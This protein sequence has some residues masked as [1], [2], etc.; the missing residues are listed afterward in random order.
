MTGALSIKDRL[1]AALPAGSLRARLASGA[2]WSLAGSVGVQ[3]AFAVTSVIV[4]RI[5]GKV[6]FGQFGMI[7]NTVL[8]FSALAGMGLGLTASKYIAEFR[9]SDPPRAGRVLGLATAWAAA[10]GLLIAVGV[11]VGADFLAE[12]TLKEPALAGYIRIC[13]PMLALAAVTGVQTGALS[14]LE[15]FRSMSAWGA[16]AAVIASVLT[17]A[18][19]YLWQLPGAL[20][21][22]VLGALVGCAFYQGLLLVLFARSGLR[23]DYRRMWQERGVLT[24]FALPS[25]LS[26][27]MMVPVTWAAAAMLARR[28][29]GWGELGVFNAANQ[30]RML[31][32]M[33]PTAAAQVVLP[34]LSSLSAGG[35]R[36]RYLRVLRV[37]AAV[38]F[39]AALA[40]ALPLAVASPWIMSLYG[41]GFRAGWPCLVFLAASAAVYAVL[42]VVGQ[43]IASL[44]RMWWGFALNLLWAVE[45]LTATWLLLPLGATGL[46]I[47]YL[48]AYG[49]HAV[50]VSLYTA[51]V[52]RRQVPQGA[53]PQTA[54][55]PAAAP[56]V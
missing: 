29:G 42:N 23:V 27:V 2:F 3:A 16:A 34:L 52:L 46:A 6:E 1:A 8:M 51:V 39:V 32:I 4:A 17:V 37:N 22:S 56:A 15:A 24:G 11:W 19:A 33:L 54:A 49:L 45:L 7:R 10:A 43:A 35:E 30:W 13:S 25:M 36:D 5:L 38:N 18:G 31:V 40:V 53:Q 47:A 50:Q 20:W 41:P 14:G 9:V 12:R 44:G 21:M 48:V 28:E 26:S 55:P